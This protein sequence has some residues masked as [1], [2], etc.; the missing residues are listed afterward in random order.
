MKVFSFSITFMLLGILNLSAQVD[1]GQDVTICNIQTVDLS[2]D[3]T[4]NS[5]GTNDYTIESIPLNMDPTATGTG[6]AT[7]TDDS[8]SGI[9]DVGFDFCFYGN[10]YNQ[11]LIST[12]N[13][14]TFDLTEANGYSLWNTYAIPSAF[15]PGQVLDAIMG[16]WMDLDPTNGGTIYYTVYGVAPFR[17]FVISFEDFGY[18]SCAGM[19]FN[20]Q[21]KLFETTNVIEIHIQDQP[22]CATWNNGESVLGIVNEDESQFLIETGWNNTQMTGNNE[23]FRFV[24][25]GAAFNNLVWTDDLGNVVGNGLNVSVDPLTTTTYTVTASECPDEFSDNVTVFVSDP[26]TVDAIVDD[27]VCPGEISGSID[28]TVNN[29]APP[30]IYQ[31]TSNNSFSSNQEDISNL[32]AGDYSLTVTD[33]LGC[34]S[35]F[36]PFNIAPPP[37]PIQ[38]SESVSPVSCFGFSDGVISVTV[39]G[40]TPNYTYAWTSSNAMTGN[41]TSIISDL[42]A[43]N[44]QLLVTDNNGCQDSVSYEV[45][46]NSSISVTSTSSDF[47]GY[48]NRCYGSNEAWVFCV[49]SGGALPYQYVWINETLDTVSTQADAYGLTAGSYTF[50]VTDAEGCPNFLTFDI[51]QPDSVS[52]DL[53]N[54]SHKSCTYNDDGFIEVATWGGPDNPINSQNYYPLSIQWTGVNSFYSTQE[55]IY[56]LT[57]GTYTV[58]VE[59]INNCSNELSFEITQPPVVIADYRVMN[60]TVTVNYPYVNLYDNSQG[61]IVDWQWEMSNGF[62]ANS[63]DVLNLN[64]STNL[65]SSGIK[66]YDFKLVVTDEYMCQDSTFGTLAIKDE[67][68]IYVPTSFTPDNDGNNDVFK[69]YHHAMKTETFSI[70]IFDRFGSVIFQ[71]NN[72]DFEWDGTN[73]FTSS[74]IITGT[75]TYVLKYQDFEYRIYDHT[76]CENCSGTITIIR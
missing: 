14:I 19:A 6:I 49:A 47:N 66:Y 30:F 21:I 60:D 3:Y 38:F 20:G 16:P 25:S 75:Y 65:D 8:Y 39:N 29:G 23:A 7:L 37:S 67:H 51:T 35:N 22:L 31:W 59:D 32:E 55:N 18:Y 12:N 53:S 57:H 4:P 43:G 9:I 36:G 2:A 69:V 62:Y 17:R 72:A 28:I 27:N 41:G 73:M 11:L 34:G 71:S 76:N 48:N 13:Y 45:G 5:V 26:A 52:I 56:N 44:Y 58:T 50:I 54:Y 15:P 46:Q 24:P 33:N 70:K 42:L 10:V 40:G 74:D 68:S 61:N 63:Q 1:A 64:L